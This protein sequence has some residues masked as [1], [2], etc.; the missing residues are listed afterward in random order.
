MNI[1]RN[2]SYTKEHVWARIEQKVAT[3][4]ITDYAQESLGD[5]IY[6]ELPSIGATIMVDN[7]IGN[8][9]AVKAVS[10]IY[11]PLSG[12]ILEVNTQL[13]SNPE[14]VNQDPYGKGWLIKIMIT[15]ANSNLLSAEEY[16]RF[17]DDQS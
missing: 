15:N 10:E 13:K 8:I 17:L 2:L 11:A 3:I 6:V 5:I 14:L 1:S 16:E 7:T 4:G 9:E 12:T